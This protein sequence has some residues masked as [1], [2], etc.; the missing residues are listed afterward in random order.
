MSR[1]ILA[2]IGVV[3]LV[4]AILLVYH[5]KP[6]PTSQKPDVAV[7]KDSQP[8]EQLSR[9]D[10]ASGEGTSL[11]SLLGTNKPAPPPILFRAGPTPEEADAPDLS[12]P[13]TAVY[14]VISL[15]DQ[16]ATDELASCFVGKSEDTAGALYP[17]YL[18]HPI[19]LVEVIEEDESAE[20]IWNATIHT[21]FSLAGQNRSPG[22]TVPLR[23]K[24]VRIENIWKI[25]KLDDGGKNDPQ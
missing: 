15:I 7:P 5:L 14:T 12:T 8:I 23:T 2:A 1:V 25:L 19:E 10:P 24:L 6:S 9:E 17:R 11:G 4:L 13:A 16:G 20:V 21:E 18:G 3:G 22:E